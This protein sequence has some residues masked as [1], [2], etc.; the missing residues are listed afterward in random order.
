MTLRDR[1]ER[2]SPRGASL[3]PVD[4]DRGQGA[5]LLDNA[6][7]ACQHRV[8]N[9]LPRHGHHLAWDDHSITSSAR[10]SNS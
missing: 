9:A 8:R 5:A 7:R 3:S 1:F 2:L 4:T 6:I 10:S